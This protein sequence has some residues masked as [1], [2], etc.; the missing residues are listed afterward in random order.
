MDYLQLSHIPYGK[1]NNLYTIRE[2][3][4]PSSDNTSI[5]RSGQRTKTKRKVLR[6]KHGE[7]RVFDE[8]FTSTDSGWFIII[9]CAGGGF[10]QQHS[11]FKIRKVAFKIT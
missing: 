5:D 8:S 7:S 4:T 9:V 1:E 2:I 6:R 3:E 10:D 11:A